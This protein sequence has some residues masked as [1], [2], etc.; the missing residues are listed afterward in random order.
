[1]LCR[2]CWTTVSAAE[3]TLSVE[4]DV[5][6]PADRMRLKQLLENL[7]KNAVEHGGE[8]VTVRIGDH[9]DG[10]Y[11]ADDGSGIPEADRETVF[12][13]VTRRVPTGRGSASTS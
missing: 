7:F 13:R 5:V 8:G 2:E 9:P 10:F 4:T 12:D 11:V 6:V 1:V 3:A